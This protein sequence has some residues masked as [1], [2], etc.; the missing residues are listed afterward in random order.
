M[1]TIVIDYRGLSKVSKQAEDLS[2]KALEYANDL[3][4]NIYKNMDDIAGAISNN[5]ESAKYY[6]N[7][8]ISELNRKKEAYQSFA[9]SVNNLIENAKRVDKEVATAIADNQERFLKNNDHLRIS[10]WKAKMLNWLVDLKNKNPLFELIGNI[11]SALKTALAGLFDNIRYWYKCEGGKERLE[12]VWAIGSAIAAVALFV[13]ALPASGFIAICAAIG[14]AITALN[15]MTNIFTSIKSYNSAKAG[16]PA[17]AKIYADQDKASD[18]FRQTRF[19]N[20]VFN[21]SSGSIAL[22][23][24][25]TQ[26]FCDV[27]GI[28]GLVKNFKFKFKSV[29]NFFSKDKG[30]LSYMKTVDYKEIYIR[31]ELGNLTEIRKVFDVNEDGVAKTRYTWESVKRGLRAFKSNSAIDGVEDKGIRTLLKD[32]F[33]SDF[34]KSKERI[35]NPSTWKDGFKNKLNDFKSF[36]NMWSEDIGWDKRRKYIKTSANT[37]KSFI[38]TSRIIESIT[39]KEFD[40]KSHITD[41]IKDF[42]D[43]TKIYSKS[44]KAIKNYNKFMKKYDKYNENLDKYSLGINYWEKRNLGIIN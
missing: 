33:K 16:D 27:V 1:Q 15:A 38:D 32:N 2:S 5:I 14:A 21:A 30:L 26:L 20:E 17:W 8:K 19:K 11:G 12:V 4:R 10:E 25:G 31:D 28:V 29:E 35:L 23:L 39:V 41:K 40:V 37:I 7:A 9:K 44:D 3:S 18:Y 43:I 6:V 34:R 42:N 24:D 22:F 36:K 13:A